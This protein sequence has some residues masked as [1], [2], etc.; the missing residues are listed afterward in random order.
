MDQTNTL[1]PIDCAC[2]IHGNAYSWTYVEKL[3]SMLTR[4]LASSVR[5]HVY[6][7]E[8]RSVPE[9]YIK[10]VLTDWGISGHRR[11]WWYKMQLFN[12]ELFAGPLLY[13]DLDIV[14]TGNIDWIAQCPLQYFWAVHDF[15]H[16]WNPT[17]YSINSSIMW[18]DTR[19]FNWVWQQFQE[20]RL[21][22]II[23]KHHGDQDYISQ[24]IIQKQRRFF[25]S[26]QIKSWRWQALDGGYN[27]QSR[28][29][30]NLGTGTEIL[31][32]TSVLVFHGKPKPADVLDPVIIQ[33]WQ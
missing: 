20:Q 13:F 21:E 25:D 19:Q 7:E 33:H 6:T 26:E 11:S 8:S 17:D 10:H 15:K 27:F 4:H 18:W 12:S 31:P 1:T 2:V 24:T 3:H 23:S 9:P 16:L 22:Q 32:S 29:Y 14:I 5:L 28:K 30:K